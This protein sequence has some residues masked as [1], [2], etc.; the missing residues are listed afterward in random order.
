MNTFVKVWWLKLEANYW[1]K[2]MPSNSDLFLSKAQKQHSTWTLLFSEVLAANF[3]SN[4]VST[5]CHGWLQGIAEAMQGLLTLNNHICKSAIT[6]SQNLTLSEK[7]KSDQFN[8]T[9]LKR[10]TKVEPVEVHVVGQHE[11]GIAAALLLC[12]P[13]RRD[14]EDG[15]RAAWGL[16]AAA[17]GQCE[18]CVAAAWGLCCSSVAEWRGV[19]LSATREVI[20][21][22]ALDAL[23]DAFGFCTYQ[24]ACQCFRACQ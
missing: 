22:G 16:R 15:V 19:G 3:H 17:R 18:G 20:V 9:L 23:V 14:S 11:G 6:F 5:L 24:C 2:A 21:E 4:S 12:A 7:L 8:S 13:L 1:Q 10:F